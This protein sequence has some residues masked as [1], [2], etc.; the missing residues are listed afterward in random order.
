MAASGGEEGD[1]GDQVLTLG[2]EPWLRLHRGGPFKHFLN[3]EFDRRRCCRCCSG[4]F[5]KTSFKCQGGRLDFLKTWKQ[6]IGSKS[7]LCPLTV[8]CEGARL[9]TLLRAE[10][11]LQIPHSPGSSSHPDQAELTLTSTWFQGVL[12]CLRQVWCFIVSGTAAPRTY[13]VRAGQHPLSA[14]RV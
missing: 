11:W 7:P 5:Q 10:I 2:E 12:A 4:G 1:E 9:H 3:R 14:C 6:C 8:S 13:G